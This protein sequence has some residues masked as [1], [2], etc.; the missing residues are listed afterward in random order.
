MAAVSE[1]GA[2]YVTRC[3]DRAAEV[4]GGG[5]PSLSLLRRI[6]A[7][8]VHDGPRATNGTK[9]A[10]KQDDSLRVNAS[11]AGVPGDEF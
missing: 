1:R 6:I 5:G 11:W 7:E 8:G 2:E 10:K 9:S 3:I 4:A